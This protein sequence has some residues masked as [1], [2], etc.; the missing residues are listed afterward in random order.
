MAAGVLLMSSAFA[1][2][3]LAAKLEDGASETPLAK[4]PPTMI[5]GGDASIRYRD[6]PEFTGKVASGEPEGEAVPAQAGRLFFK[7][8]KLSMR[9]VLADVERDRILRATVPVSFVHAAME[10]AK[11]TGEAK[12]ERFTV[13]VTLAETPPGFDLRFAGFH[14]RNLHFDPASRTLTAENLR[15]ADKDYKSIL[16]AAADPGMRDAMNELYIASAKY[17]VGWWW[18]LWFYVLSTL[19]E[20]CLSP[21]GLSMVSKL[22]PARFATMLMGMWLLTS[23]FGNFLAGQ[24][25]ESWGTVSPTAYFIWL[26]VALGAASAVLFG[27]VPKVVK[28]MHGVN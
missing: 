1:V 6:A 11:Q 28:M 24:L 19:G 22:A 20:L 4:L 18:L 21:V 2:M 14:P 12:G 23:F 13:A 25:G 8:G 26:V 7:E 17:K 9:G 3:I 5:A 27:I 16:Q 10:L 15:L